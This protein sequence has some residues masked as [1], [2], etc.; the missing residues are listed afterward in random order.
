MKSPAACS[1]RL[2]IHMKQTFY[3]N[4]TRRVIVI[5]LLF[6]NIVPSSSNSAKIIYYAHYSF[7]GGSAWEV[8]YLSATVGEV[9]HSPLLAVALIH[10]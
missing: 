7:I 6:S 3:L 4:A 10:T 1:K 5:L 9:N 8:E 2:Y